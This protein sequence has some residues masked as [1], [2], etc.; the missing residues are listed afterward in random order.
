MSA[1]FSARLS[2]RPM[3]GAANCSARLALVLIF[4]ALPVDADPASY[5]VEPSLTAVEFVATQFGVFLARGRF[6][7][8]SGRIVYDPAGAA[9]SVAFDLAAASVTTGW[10]ARD[11]FIRGEDMFDAERHPVIRF[12]STRLTFANGT[13]ARIDGELTLRDVTRPLSLHIARFDCGKM[14]DD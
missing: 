1:T 2:T 14:R 11:A 6:A 7:R 12:R 9:S 4:V 3:G 8:M 13:P 10:S 5:R